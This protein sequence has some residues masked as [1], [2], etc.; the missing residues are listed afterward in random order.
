MFVFVR[1]KEGVE[2]GGREREGFGLW[3]TG[4]P[5]S[6]LEKERLTGGFRADMVGFVKAIM[7][8]PSGGLGLV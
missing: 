3:G 8:V 5:S 6:S 1:G 7:E 2:V 4:L